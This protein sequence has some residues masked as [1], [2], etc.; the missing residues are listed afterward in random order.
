MGHKEHIKDENRTIEDFLKI[1]FYK[2]GNFWRAYEWSAY[3][4]EFFP[5]GLSENDKL[6]PTYKEIKGVDGG[7]IF[8]GLPTSSFKK[9]FPSLENKDFFND[10]D[11]V[12][13]IDVS[14]E[15][16]KIAFENIENILNEWKEKYRTNPPK[17]STNSSNTF[18]C[19]NTNDIIQ[20]LKAFPIESKSPIE[21]LLFLSDLKKK[22][23]NNHIKKDE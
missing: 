8:V 11:G 16:N 17:L 2:E 22:I 5:N 14:K 1:K 15:F 7:I 9:F 12:K 18:K 10:K 6:K 3:L 23:F 4:C 21:C 13:L 19:N 20:S